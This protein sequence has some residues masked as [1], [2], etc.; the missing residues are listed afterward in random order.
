M[1][2][3]QDLR[4]GDVLIADTYDAVRSNDAAWNK[5]LLIVTF[6][7]HG[8]FFDHVLPPKAPNPD[9]INSPAPGDTAT[10]NLPV[11]DFSRL[12]L[13]VPTILASPWIAKGKVI[14]TQ[15]QHTSV[16]ATLR[17]LWDV[18]SLTKRDKGATS[19]LPELSNT[20]RSD[21]IAQ[22]PRVAALEGVLAN[23][24]LPLSD[25][26]H[27]ANQQTDDTQDE[28]VEGWRDRMRRVMPNVRQSFA[29]VLTNGAAHEFVRSSVLRYLDARAQKRK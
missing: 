10:Y 27:P 26:H 3:P 28:I 4:P 9:G 25:P 23:A 2:A 15:L 12:G 14:S 8:G 5:T 11:F 20:A 18:A 21:T 19:L 7:E 16:L 1:H 17:D 24:S 29:P 22:L 6:D 13:R